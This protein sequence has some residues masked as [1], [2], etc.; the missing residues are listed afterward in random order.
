MQ[1]T[2]KNLHKRSFSIGMNSRSWE[3]FP[4]FW[5]DAGADGSS[6]SGFFGFAVQFFTIFF[7]NF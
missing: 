1:M 5:S 7:T 4:G 2:L 6:F 3:E